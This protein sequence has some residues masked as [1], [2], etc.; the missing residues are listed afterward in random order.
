MNLHTRAFR[1]LNNMWVALAIGALLGSAARLSADAFFTSA[2]H[3]P[4]FASTVAVNLLG[5]LF[6]CG[7]TAR[8]HRAATSSTST[9]G[10]MLL[11]KDSGISER[12]W[13]IW[14][15]GF[16]GSFTTYSALALSATHASAGYPLPPSWIDEAS[17]PLPLGIMAGAIMGIVGA[18]FR[19]RFNAWLTLRFTAVQK[20]IALAADCRRRKEECVWATLTRGFTVLAPLMGIAV[21]NVLGSGAAGFVAGSYQMCLAQGAE[22]GVIAFAWLCTGSGILGAFTTFST[23]VVDAWMIVRRGYVWGG[24]LIFAGVWVFAWGACA[25]GWKIAGISA[26]GAM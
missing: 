13:V 15:T 8:R 26:C 2:L 17:V 4:V 1:S 3:A 18:T 21:I 12:A 23:A 7:L 6:L 25:L 5:T 11:A 14:A 16:C 22:R 10:G 20:R 19:W 24:A 9:T